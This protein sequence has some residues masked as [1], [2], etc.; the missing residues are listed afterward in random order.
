MVLLYIS[1]CVCLVKS[2]A[3][4]GACGYIRAIGAVHRG[5]WVLWVVFI[6]IRAGYFF[7]YFY[8]FVTVLCCVVT[9]VALG[10]LSLLWLGFCHDGILLRG[11]WPLGDPCVM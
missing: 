10:C 6:Y 1:L 2:L 8:F 7:F 4:A 9:L 5:W 11:G 3:E